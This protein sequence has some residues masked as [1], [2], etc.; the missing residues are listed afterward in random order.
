M[1]PEQTSLYLHDDNFDL[2]SRY[3]DP[4]KVLLLYPTADASL[5]SDIETSDYKT[6]VVI[7]GTWRQAKAM[8]K[9]Y[10]NMGFKHVKIALHETLFWRYQNLDRTFLATIE[11]IYWLFVEYHQASTNTEYDGRYDDLLFYFKL[12]FDL[13]QEFYK[14]RP[15]KPFTPRHTLADSFIM[16]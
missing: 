9:Q 5:L 8:A 1:S 10:G 12:K 7:D 2:S 6:L 11:A 14:A 3:P 16:Y 13:I 15:G 4:S